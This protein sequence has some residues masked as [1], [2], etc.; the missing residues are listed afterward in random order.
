M[1]GHATGQSLNDNQIIDNRISI[2]NAAM[3]CVNPAGSGGGSATISAAVAFHLSAKRGCRRATI[4]RRPPVISSTGNR[5]R[6][7]GYSRETS[8]MIGYWGVNEPN[9]PSASPL[10]PAVK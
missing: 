7:V 10:S 9:R 5:S 1:R 8:P 2:A 4:T 3:L 6:D